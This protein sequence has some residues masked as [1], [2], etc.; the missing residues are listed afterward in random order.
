MRAHIAPIA[1]AGFLHLQKY[2]LMSS[3]IEKIDE[4]GVKGSFYRAVVA[5]HQ[6]SAGER[7]SFHSFFFFITKN[8]HTSSQGEFADSKKLIHKARKYLDIELTALVSESYERAYPML[9]IVQQLS[10]LEEVLR[11][12]FFFLFFLIKLFCFVFRLLSTRKM[13]IEENQFKKCGKRGLIFF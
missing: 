8:T 1:A 13:K 4:E 6:V 10:E 11:E 9:C 3:F 2:D 5:C 12:S 7:F